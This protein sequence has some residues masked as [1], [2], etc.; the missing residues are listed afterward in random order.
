MLFVLNL[1][2]FHVVTTLLL[3]P[4][5]CYL[6][7][8]LSLRERLEYSDMCQ[9]TSPVLPHQIISRARAKTPLPIS[10]E[11]GLAACMN[12]V[13]IYAVY[14]LAWFSIRGAS[15]LLLIILALL[16]LAKAAPHP[17]HLALQLQRIPLGA[18]FWSCYCNSN[19]F[20]NHLPIGGLNLSCV[21]WSS[22]R[23]QLWML[24]G[25]GIPIPFWKSDFSSVAATCMVT[26]SDGWN[27]IFDVS[28]MCQRR[29]SRLFI[30][31]SSLN[32]ILLNVRRNF[33]NFADCRSSQTNGSSSTSEIYWSPLE[34]RYHRFSIGV[35]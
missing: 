27:L 13:N 18:C 2:I 12:V 28:D 17:E 33:L 7:S 15:K 9:S 34:S 31:N 32:S 29:L 23:T 3:T 6:S 1:E 8:W 25:P 11:S 19:R 24:A 4:L 14:R 26:T 21:I 5:W 20:Q 35:Q 10:D 16:Q 22:H 30:L